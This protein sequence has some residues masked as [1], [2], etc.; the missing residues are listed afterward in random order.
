MARS[1]MRIDVRMKFRPFIEAVLSRGAGLLRDI[2]ASIM[3]LRCVFCGTRSRHPEIRICTACHAELPRPE[4]ACARC[5]IP[6]TLRLPDGVHCAAC[7]QKPPPFEATIAPLLY[8]FPVDAALKALKFSRRLYYAA[9]F[10]ELLQHELPRLG[11]GVDALLPVPL[12][13]RRH[14][15]RGFNQ[16][17][18]LCK[19]LA[20]ATALPVMSGVVRMRPTA[21]QSGLPAASRRRNLKRAFCVKKKPTA[22]HVVIVDDVVTTG[23]TTRQ[24]G[25]ALLRAGVDRVSVLAVARAR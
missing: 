12:H 2:D 20:R 3:P 19:P 18:E 9:A 14:A 25:S 13:W 16:A 6:T 4:N 7:Q 24:L 17:T 8:E 23:A 21:F 5:A 15:W 1:A 22:R 10:A 11:P